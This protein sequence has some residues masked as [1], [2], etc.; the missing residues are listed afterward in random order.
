M[1]DMLTH[2]FHYLSELVN[3]IICSRNSNIL[4]KICMHNRLGSS[5]CVLLKVLQ[6]I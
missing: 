2:I 6:K 5:E 4:S 1:D 3:I